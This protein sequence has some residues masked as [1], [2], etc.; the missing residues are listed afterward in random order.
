MLK[1]TIYITNDINLCLANLNTCKTII[2]ADEPHLYSIPDGIAGSILMPSYQALEALL[3]EDFISFKFEY[4]NYL[5]NDITAVRFIN[6]ILQALI[7]GTNILLFVE[8]EANNLDYTVALKEFFMENFGIVI[9]DQNT[10]FK[11]N[12]TYYPVILNRL[13]AEDEISK[14]HYLKLFPLEFIFDIFSLRKLSYDYGMVF[15]D[16]VQA[17]MYFKK[18]SKILKNGGLIQGVVKR[19]G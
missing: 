14:E 15:V 17:A 7:V 6:I 10:T 3:D 11:Y 8:K 4:N 13:Y 16:D 9:G 5:S 1:G 18:L 12:I 19:L 2:V